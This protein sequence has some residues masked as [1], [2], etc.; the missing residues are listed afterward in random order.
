MVAHF[1]MM[2]LLIFYRKT[3]GNA[4]E[5][6]A[7]ESGSCFLVYSHYFSFRRNKQASALEP[8]SINR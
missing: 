2:R 1:F 7:Q 3:K 6:N 4:F 5:I 8:G